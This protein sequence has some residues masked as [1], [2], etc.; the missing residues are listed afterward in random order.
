MNYTYIKMTMK[1]PEDQTCNGMDITAQVLLLLCPYIFLFWQWKVN[2]SA[3]YSFRSA[4]LHWDESCPTF[5][6]ISKS[7]CVI[8]L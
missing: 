6:T 8:M 2:I 1:N 3:L 7:V 5:E 4:G